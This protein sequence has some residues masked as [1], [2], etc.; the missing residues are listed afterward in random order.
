MVKNQEGTIL[1]HPIA[2]SQFDEQPDI[3]ACQSQQTNE[4]IQFELKHKTE[5][6]LKELNK[7]FRFYTIK[8]LREAFIKHNLLPYR[9]S[10]NGNLNIY[11]PLDK[12]VVDAQYLLKKNKMRLQTFT[13]SNDQFYEIVRE[14]TKQVSSKHHN[15][16]EALVDNE[17]SILDDKG[18]HRIELKE[19]DLES[20][21]TYNQV[22][23]K[24]D[25]KEQNMVRTAVKT[26][27]EY[28]ANKTIEKVHCSSGSY[29]D[30]QG[31]SLWEKISHQLMIELL[32][33][34]DW[35]N[36]ED[37]KRERREKCTKKRKGRYM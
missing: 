3:L 11:S 15:I 6:I 23:S 26:H 29:Q 9:L 28:L 37:K 7:D 16:A 19:L 5:Q 33:Y 2:L 8:E 34:N 18:N 10:K 35:E 32:N 12:T 22:A 27:L 13:L 14:F 20:C 30:F 36:Q 31:R 24:L 17:Q 4:K 21:E 1:R 25:E